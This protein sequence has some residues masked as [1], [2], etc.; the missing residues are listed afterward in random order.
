[1]GSTMASAPL[2]L[3]ILMSGAMTTAHAGSVIEQ[4]EL[5][6]C[7]SES[8]LSPLMRAVF[9]GNPDT[10]DRLL[11]AGADPNKGCGSGETTSLLLVLLPIVWQERS[12]QIEEGLRLHEHPGSEADLS[13]RKHILLALLSY[14]ADPNIGEHGGTGTYPLTV[15]VGSDQ[16]WAAELLIAHGAAPDLPPRLEQLARAIGNRAMIELLGF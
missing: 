4:T 14:G 8:S 11:N 3:G 10:V 15:A 1:M 12:G 13:N 2:F 7:D 5:D 16:L 6:T 9:V